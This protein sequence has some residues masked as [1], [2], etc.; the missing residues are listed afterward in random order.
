MKLFCDSKAAIQIASHPIFHESTKHFD[1]DC[2]FVREK[3]IEGLIQTQH[4]RTKEQQ[5]DLPT[6]GLCKPQHEALINKLGMKNVFFNS[7]LVGE[8]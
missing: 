2:H 1:I 5:V 6:K 7:Q 8:C 4:I 3:I